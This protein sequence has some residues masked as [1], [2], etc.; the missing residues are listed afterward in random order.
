M[1]AIVRM[2]VT[3]L[4]LVGWGLAASSLHVVWTGESPIVIPKHRLGVADTYVDVSKWKSVD[5]VSNHAVVCRRLIATD[6]TEC[7]SH[8]FKSSSKNDL[9]NKVTA[10]VE[11]GDSLPKTDL[12]NDA[13]ALASKAKNALAQ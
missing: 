5:D 11:R 10:A 8:L 7:L 12:V 4:L 2:F 6:K 3:L 1:K 13:Q 9:I